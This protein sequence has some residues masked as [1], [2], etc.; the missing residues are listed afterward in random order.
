[1]LAKPLA[2]G[3]RVLQGAEAGRGKVSTENMIGA[4]G[5]PIQEMLCTS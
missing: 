3:S 4:Y 5:A 1:M 2:M